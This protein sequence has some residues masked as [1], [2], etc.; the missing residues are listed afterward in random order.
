MRNSGRIL[1]RKKYKISAVPGCL[2]S[3]LPQTGLQ[4]LAA[5]CVGGPA[6]V[7]PVIILQGGHCGSLREI[8]GIERRPDAVEQFG[9]SGIRIPVSD[10]KT[11]QSIYFGKGAGPDNLDAFIDE[12]LHIK[13]LRFVLRIGLV[14]AEDDPFGKRAGKACDFVHG[15]PRTGGIIRIGQEDQPGLFRYGIQHGIEVMD[16]A[17]HGDGHHRGSRQH[18]GDA[19]GDEGKLT[20]D[21]FLSRPGKHIAQHVENLIGAGGEGQLVRGESVLSR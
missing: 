6:A 2:E 10:P 8:A 19:V 11:C 17:G 21:D 7:N 13:G 4:L 20:D 5:G 3:E 18:G 16:K 15:Q 12:R 1:Q 14:V 9:E